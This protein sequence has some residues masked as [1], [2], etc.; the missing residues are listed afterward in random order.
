[1]GLMELLVF[2]DSSAD[3]A[4]IAIATAIFKLDKRINKLE[5]FIELYF[6]L[7]NNKEL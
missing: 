4:M 6:K 7:K 5:N 2:L 3:V 1:M